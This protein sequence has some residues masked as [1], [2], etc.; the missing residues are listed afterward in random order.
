MA[1][2]LERNVT[3]AGGGVFVLETLLLTRLSSRKRENKPTADWERR[4][5][6]FLPSRHFDDFTQTLVE[7]C[8]PQSLTSVR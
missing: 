3:D 5:V 4:L 1:C 2:R 6:L 8:L 7:V